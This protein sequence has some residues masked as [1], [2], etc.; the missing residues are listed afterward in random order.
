MP[1][2]DIVP[3]YDSYDQEISGA[4][5]G[6]F[7]FLID[8]SA[9]MIEPMG[10]SSERKCD[11]LVKAINKFLETLVIMNSSGEDEFKDRMDIGVIGYRT[12][13]DGNPIVE[14]VLSGPLAEKDLV[15][16]AELA[17]NAEYETME[18]K[19]VDPD[20]G[21][22]DSMTVDV[23]VWVKPVYEGGTPMCSALYRCY[24]ILDQWIEGHRDSFP[25]MLI[26]FSDGECIEDTEEDADPVVAPIPY[27][28][29]VRSLETDDGNVL[30]MN[31]HLSM[32]P[33]DEILFPNSDEMLPEQLARVLYK[34]SSIIP[35]KMRD[36]AEE[37][38]FEL[39]HDA[40]AM[41]FNADM[42]CLLRFLDVGTRVATA[43]PLR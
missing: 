7:L 15:T 4:H 42:A 22:L 1:E 41:A 29:S 5:K 31:C 9:S 16:V 2:Y 24:E 43:K 23:P 30:V 35:P 20:T 8:Q 6:C 40:R 33:S 12:D 13:P 36:L 18:K 27:A 25:P 11:Q 17:A 14:R 19:I 39:Q 10:N 26:H 3:E 38:G 28:D 32:T 37:G 34:M 21:E